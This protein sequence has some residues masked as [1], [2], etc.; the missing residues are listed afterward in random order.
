MAHIRSQ[1]REDETGEG[2]LEFGPTKD[3][4]GTPPEPRGKNEN[5]W[6]STKG[7]KAENVMVNIST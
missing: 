4:S 1:E 6:C 3:R 5:I 2:L 7:E